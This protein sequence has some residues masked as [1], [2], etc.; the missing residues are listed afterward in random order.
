MLTHPLFPDPDRN[1]LKPTP[2]PTSTPTR[3]GR[4]QVTVCDV[5]RLDPSLIQAE[6]LFCILALGGGM[7]NHSIF[8]Y[9]YRIDRLPR[10]LMHNVLV[11]ARDR[12]L[13][14]D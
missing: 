1:L 4:L 12:Q 6:G 2:V 3:R 9:V 11:I 10:R 13:S 14:V 5:S 7:L 8:I